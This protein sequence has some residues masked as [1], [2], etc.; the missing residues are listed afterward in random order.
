M[1][2]AAGLGCPH[3]AM[4]GTPVERD[5]TSAG[6]LR[7]FCHRTLLAVYLGYDRGDSYD[8]WVSKWSQRR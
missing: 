3:P 2:T 4:R 5:L 1:Y 7:D 6:E 8:H